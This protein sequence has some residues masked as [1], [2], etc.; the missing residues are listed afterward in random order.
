MAAAPGPIDEMQRRDLPS[1]RIL[2]PFPLSRLDPSTKMH[3]SQIAA[4]G[5][6]KLFLSASAIYWEWP[7][8]EAVPLF[9]AFRPNTP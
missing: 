3:A 1:A 5:Q 4:L 7:S 2:P 8:C 9:P 6:R